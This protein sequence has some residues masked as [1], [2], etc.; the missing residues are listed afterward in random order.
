MEF[1]ILLLISVALLVIVNENRKKAV[2]NYLKNFFEIFKENNKKTIKEIE[3]LE[4]EF[5]LKMKYDPKN[6]EVYDSKNFTTFHILRNKNNLVFFN[7]YKEKSVLL[8]SYE[9]AA[10]ESKSG[11]LAMFLF[12][13][14]SNRFFD[15][16]QGDF[17]SPTHRFSNTNYVLE[18]LRPRIEDLHFKVNEVKN[19]FSYKLDIDN[20]IYYSKTG[21]IDYV[22]KVSGGGSSVSGAILGGLLA[23]DT[24][25]IIASREKVT[26]D[27]EEIDTRILWLLYKEK[28]V[29]KKTQLDF[30]LASIF[31]KL[32]PE[33]E[34]EYS[35]IKKNYRRAKK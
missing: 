23:G 13:Y 11:D 6:H 19:I 5:R 26:T 30:K 18:I 27:T 2:K 21:K 25:A 12:V 4:K 35:L 7:Q 15:E 3:S 24:G 20:I 31:D 22:T 17:S 34:Y 14:F 32:I 16:T 29:V 8:P 10:F 28:G 33:K 9:P 1:I